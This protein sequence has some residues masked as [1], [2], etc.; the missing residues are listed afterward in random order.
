MFWS[1]GL[2]DL[3][4]KKKQVR[5][6]ETSGAVMTAVYSYCTHQ[7]STL[8]M[9][10]CLR[11]EM[12]FFNAKHSVFIFFPFFFWQISLFFSPCSFALRH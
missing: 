5:E 10:A 8:L 9:L 11:F 7:L 2:F 1:H 3:K 4:K 12:V 6:G